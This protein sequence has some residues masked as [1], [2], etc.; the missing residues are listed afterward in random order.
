MLEN[1]T[2]IPQKQRKLSFPLLPIAI[3]FIIVIVASFIFIRKY[4]HRHNV[5]NISGEDQKQS[6]GN[7]K[8]ENQ[9]TQEGMNVPISIET[10]TND[11]LIEEGNHFFN[12]QNFQEAIQAYTRAIDNN[13]RNEIAYKN[14]SVAYVALDNY[15]AAIDD[16]NNIL[17]MNSNSAE[18]YFYRGLYMLLLCKVR[19]YPTAP[20]DICQPKEMRADIERAAKLG[21]KQ[22]QDFLDVSSKIGAAN[23]GTEI[24]EQ[25][26]SFEE[27]LKSYKQEQERK[28]DQE[29]KQFFEKNRKYYLEQE[30]KYKRGEK[31]TGNQKLQICQHEAEKEFLGKPP[32]KMFDWD[33][34]LIEIIRETITLKCEYG[35]LYTS[36]RVFRKAT[37]RREVLAWSENLDTVVCP[38]TVKKYGSICE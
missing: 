4:N 24:N 38:E 27:A 15:K 6:Q 10:N 13:P 30:Q 23:H 3:I 14:R 5:G 33:G 26:Q 32:E 18:A 29:I 35:Q 34:R 17:A 19:G 11:E 8:R 16:V 12:K 2:N 7:M 25:E 22:A 31:V 37:G 28:S 36:G 9:L 20:T 21:W 1:N